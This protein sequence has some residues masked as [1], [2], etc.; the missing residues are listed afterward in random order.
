MDDARI[1]GSLRVGQL[2]ANHVNPAEVE[3]H[4]VFAYGSPGPVAASSRVPC[5]FPKVQ[6]RWDLRGWLRVRNLIRQ[7]QPDIVHFQ[8]PLFILRIFL[9]DCPIIRVTHC[10]GR[11]LSPPKSLVQRL[12]SQWQRLTTDCFVCINPSA[13]KT[14]ISFG[15]A[16]P[17]Q[18]QVLPNA[19][20]VAVLQNRPNKK[21]ARASLGLPQDVKLLGMVGRVIETKGFPDLFQIIRKLPDSWQTAVF[22]DGP[23]RSPLEQQVQQEGLSDRIHFLG[24]LDDIRPAYAAIDAF[25]FISRHEPFGL[26]IAEAMACRVPVFGLHGLGEYRE[27]EPPLVDQQVATFFERENPERVMHISE[28]KIPET[29]HILQQLSQAIAAFDPDSGEVYQKIETAFQRIQQHYD[30]KAQAV[31][32]THIYQE[33]MASHHGH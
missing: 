22:G 1:G 12:A 33:L 14:L 3:A 20:D 16:T 15:L 30:V 26:V 31:R 32:M 11:P 4:L 5:H 7:L 10:H 25:I 18:C 23:D 6:G 8:D 2:L 17:E 27:L 21:T 29:D 9:S 19:V 24:S 28:W 13:A